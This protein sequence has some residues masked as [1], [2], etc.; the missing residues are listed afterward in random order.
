MSQPNTSGKGDQG[1][2]DTAP[3][4]QPMSQPSVF[5]PHPNEMIQR[6]IC[7][8]SLEPIN[9]VLFSVGPFEEGFPTAPPIQSRRR[10]LKPH[11][12]AIG[13]PESS[14]QRCKRVRYERTI[15]S[16]EISGSDNDCRAE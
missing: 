15:E 5:S 8:N 6:K 9:R 4:D 10:S 11:Y 14:K 7:D 16:G 12:V 13:E 3:H 2:N 1:R